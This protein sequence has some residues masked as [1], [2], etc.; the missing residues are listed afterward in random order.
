MTLERKIFSLFFLPIDGGL[1]ALHADG[2]FLGRIFLIVFEAVGGDVA[3][4]AQ[5]AARQT[6]PDGFA[7]G[8]H[9]ERKEKKETNER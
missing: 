1:V 3:A 6:K 8:T 7:A 2:M 5:L 9:C 4:A